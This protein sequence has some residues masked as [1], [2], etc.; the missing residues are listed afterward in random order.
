MARA[1]LASAASLPDRGAGHLPLTIRTIELGV[2]AAD[3]L[4]DRMDPPLR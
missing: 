4:V 3:S 1:L 2:I